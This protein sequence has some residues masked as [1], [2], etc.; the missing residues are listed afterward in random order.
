M[1]CHPIL[2]ALPS[3]TRTL[4]IMYVPPPPPPHSR[5]AK[6]SRRGP[7]SPRSACS[8]CTRPPPPPLRP[9]PSRPCHRHHRPRRPLGTGRRRR[10]GREW[11][12]R[13]P[14]TFTP[15]PRSTRQPLA[16]PLHPPPLLPARRPSARPPCGESNQGRGI[17]KGCR[18]EVW[19]GTLLTCWRCLG[20]RRRWCRTWRRL[21]VWLARRG[22]RP[23][24]GQGAQVLRMSR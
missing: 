21:R 22:R 18:H 7:Q 20:R 5:P 23:L 8:T 24:G 4:Y 11:P 1:Y 17:R 16:R 12:R 14:P 10:H 6:P 3:C 15:P 13:P 9:P 19:S 2:L